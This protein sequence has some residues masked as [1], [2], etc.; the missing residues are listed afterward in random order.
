MRAR[1]RVLA[2][3][4]RPDPSPWWL[5]WLM[6][7]LSVLAFAAIGHAQPAVPPPGTTAPASPTPPVT[8]KLTPPTQRGVIR[9]R[10]SIDPGIHAPA[11]PVQA[12]K[13]PVIKPPG[14]VGGNPT[15]QP[16]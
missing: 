1:A 4:Q 6:L 11:P 7:M 15:V 10:T 2:L 13:M 9:P 5:L 3:R 12:F 16:K 8:P 14:T